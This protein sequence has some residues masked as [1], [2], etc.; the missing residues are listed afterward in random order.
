MIRI[1]I[2]DDEPIFLKSFQSKLEEKRKELKIDAI[3]KSYNNGK[4]FLKEIS[5][6]D[7]VF[8]D[9]D[10]PEIN[11]MEIALSI[12]QNHPVPILFLTAHDEL[13]YSSI[14]FHPFRFIRKAYIDS[15]L[16]EAVSALSE[17]IKVQ[18]QNHSVDLHTSEGNVTLCIRNIVFAEIYGHWIKIHTTDGKVY[19]CYG[20]L[21]AYEKQ[22]EEFSFARTHKSYLVNC[23]YIYSIQKDTVILDSGEKILLSR[24][25]AK[26]VREKFEV[27]MRS[28]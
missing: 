12:N 3:V 7:A 4:E 19:E 18:F 24:N 28:M 9:I 16:G 20:S 11:G 8:L 2:C 27:M 17:H 10:M 25:K 1:A 22:W 13:V 15:E 6:F 21:S 14:Q 23:R 26:T 5:D